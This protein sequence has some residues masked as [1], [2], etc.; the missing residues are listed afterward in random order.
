LKKTSFIFL[1]II[2]CHLK[3]DAQYQYNGNFHKIDKYAKNAPDSVSNN[4]LSLHN[5]L[6]NSAKNNTEKLRAFYIWIINH[7][8]YED[9][10][11]LIYNPDILFYMGTKNCSS[12]VCV[13]TVKKAV[14]E[15][16]SNLF[17]S[18]C[19]LSG[20]ESYTIAGY[21]KQN[22]ILYDRAS[23]A[24]NVVKV[25]DQWFFFDPTW[26]SATLQHSPKNKAATNALFM[27]SPQKF[28]EDHL[29][30]IPL[31]QFIDKPVPFT[32]FNAGKERIIEFIQQKQTTPNYHFTDSLQAFNQLPVAQQR[33]KTGIE[34]S[35]TNPSNKF[36]QAIEYYRFAHIVFNYQKTRVNKSADSLL[37][38]KTYL[39]KS[40][41]LLQHQTDVAS[42][43]MKIRASQDLQKIQDF[44][45]PFSAESKH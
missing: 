14:C 40:I 34:I 18:L 12:P 29:P 3:L 16:Y 4:L 13:L 27:V 35:R 15:G 7:I 38:A 5:Y 6:S 8:R 9:Q 37:E 45:K 30:L 25:D 41:F 26:A 22:S 11:E 44:I 1:A 20:F 21:V 28:I 32:I 33:L 43:L 39:Q 19:Q 23:H 2:F 42:K 24:W 17:Q 31:W 36:D 10:A